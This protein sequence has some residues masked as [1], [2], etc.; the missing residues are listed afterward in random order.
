MKYFL[1]LLAITSLLIV[2]LAHADDP[3]PTL[4]QRLGGERVVTRVVAQTVRT[5]ADDP[6]TNRTFDGIDAAT[7]GAKI[8]VQICALS[9]GGCKSDA[10]DLHLA[11]RRTNAGQRDFYALVGALRAALDANGVGEREKSELLTLLATT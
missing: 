11:Q 4:Y 9:G 10:D 1:I 2:E 5:L 3:D 8:V 7:L 6:A